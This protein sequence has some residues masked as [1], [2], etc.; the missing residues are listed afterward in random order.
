M[1]NM[2]RRGRIGSLPI[3]RVGW[4]LTVNFQATRVEAPAFEA[5]EFGTLDN[6]RSTSDIGTF[7]NTTGIQ[8]IA[9][10]VTKQPFFAGMTA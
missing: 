4:W 1:L 5:F 7:A 3:P 9:L 8:P 6:L 2:A 10:F